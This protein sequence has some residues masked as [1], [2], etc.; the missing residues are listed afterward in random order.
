MNLT[1]YKVYNLQSGEVVYIT[2]SFSK[3]HAYINNNCGI[4]GIYQYGIRAEKI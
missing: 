2:Y 4:N 1:V 3:A